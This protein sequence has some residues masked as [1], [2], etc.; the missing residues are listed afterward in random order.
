LLKIVFKLETAWSL[1]VA[2]ESTSQK[3]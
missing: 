3:K 1:M 2:C